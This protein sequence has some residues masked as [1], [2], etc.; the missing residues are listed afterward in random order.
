[1]KKPPAA[2]SSS[3]QAPAKPTKA[4]IVE[5]LKYKFNQEDAEAQAESV[6]PANVYADL[7]SS[8]WKA[9]LE[10][11]DNLHAWIESGEGTSA[12]SEIIVRYFSKKPGWKES[13]FQVRSW[14]TVAVCNS[15]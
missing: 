10:A 2:S 8:N 15:I 6:L 13:N 5:P 7:S 1:M 9:R 4:A 11:L 12:E 14:A 3:S